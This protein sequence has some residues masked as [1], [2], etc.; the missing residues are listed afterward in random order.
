MDVKILTS[1]GMMAPASV[2]QV[3]I[4]ESFHHKVVSPPRFGI[5]WLETR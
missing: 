1:S 5:I 3:M 2:P 4:E